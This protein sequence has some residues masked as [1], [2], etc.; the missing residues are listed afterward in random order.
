MYSLE[1]YHIEPTSA[2]ADVIA[3]TVKIQNDFFF[4]ELSRDCAQL[5]GY[6]M[7]WLFVL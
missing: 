6:V 3:A 5:F 1:I 7:C 2:V 4:K